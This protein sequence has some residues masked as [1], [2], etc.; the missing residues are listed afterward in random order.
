MDKQLKYTIYLGIQ[1]DVLVSGP[2]LRDY[3]VLQMLNRTL[4]LLL[5]I[6]R[7]NE[8]PI[9][10]HLHIIQGVSLDSPSCV[11]IY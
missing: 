2:G 8:T 6:L 4:L 5:R 10:S 1:V 11:S 9:L 3:F 7:P